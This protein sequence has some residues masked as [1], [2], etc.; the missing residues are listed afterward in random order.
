MNDVQ[1]RVRKVLQQSLGLNA[2][3]D[4]IAAAA[5]VDQLLGLD[6]IAM[7]EFVMALEQEFALTFDADNLDEELFGDLERLSAHIAGRLGS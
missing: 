1:E 2:T 6:S 5:S 4:E 7:L 3:A